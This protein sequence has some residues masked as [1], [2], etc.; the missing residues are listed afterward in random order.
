MYARFPSSLRN[1]EVLL[2]ER[3]IDI[4]HQTVRLPWNRFG[5][6]FAGEVRKQR[7]YRMRSFP[8]WRTRT[9]CT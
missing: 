1:V 8:E 3:S 4:C 6:L 7:V 9:R 2:S 5:P